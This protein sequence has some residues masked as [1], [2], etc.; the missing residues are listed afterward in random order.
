M[1]AMTAK[2]MSILSLGD[3]PLPKEALSVVGVCMDD[4]NWQFLK[5]FADTTGLVQVRSRVDDYRAQDR[6]TI[7]DYLGDPLPDICL[8]D[9]DGNRHG[10]S[11]A[12]ERIHAAAPGTAIFAV[13]S[14]SQPDCILE[15]MRSGCTEYLTKP[16]ERE[17][18]VNA[19]ARVGARHREKKDLNRAQVMA[20]IGSKGG[21]GVTTL[22]TQLGAILSKSYSR[23]SL[24][25]DLHPDF[26]DAALYLKLNRPSYHFFELLENTHRLDADFLQSFLMQHSSGVDL[27]GAPEGSES[28]REVPPGSLSQTFDF[29]RS[30]YEFILVD[31]PVG[32]NEKN[33]ELMR[34]CD[35]IYLVTIAEVSAVRN[36]VRQFEY[37]SRADIPRDKIRV[38]LNRYEKRN[39]IADNQIEKVIEQKIYWRVPNHYP[40]V[41]KTIHAGDPIAQLSSSE[42]GANLKE[43]AGTI[44][45]KPGEEKKKEGGGL[46]GFWNR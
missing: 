10:A 25:V 7:A 38:V 21:C 42:V 19:V 28:T 9:F 6:E 44:G 45:K 23:K 17:Q 11:N 20:F 30:R 3:S 40:Q 39:I 14:H 37:F 34:Y 15:A 43:W 32:L 24:V 4:E 41:V 26:G 5:A 35:Q 46:L 13:S 27:I 16:L 36:V 18:L 29:L 31:L 8:M 33:L 1:K 22:V 12:A 2:D